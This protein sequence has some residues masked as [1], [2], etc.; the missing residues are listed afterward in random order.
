MVVE[1]RTEYV[2]GLHAVM[3]CVKSV[4]VSQSARFWIKGQW[5]APP[6]KFRAYPGARSTTETA[7]DSSK[8]RLN[9]K[10][11][12]LNVL[13][14]IYETTFFA[15]AFK[16]GAGPAKSVSTIE[17]KTRLRE[18]YASVCVPGYRN[19]G[20]A[21][22]SLKN[23]DWCGPE[24]LTRY[25]ISDKLHQQWI[26]EKVLVVLRVLS[27]NHAQIT[28]QSHEVSFILARWKVGQWSL[29]LPQWLR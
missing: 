9:I 24:A 20:S 28:Q 27:R 23:L 5:A 12:L 22:C 8:K 16:K 21:K 11:L 19:P 17:I 13:F 6:K 7:S 4:A 1:S 29:S 14:L 18:I 26:M 10:R 3:Q 2:R 25:E 15:R